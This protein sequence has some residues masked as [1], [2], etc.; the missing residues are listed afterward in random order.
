MTPEEFKVIK[1]LFERYHWA[2]CIWADDDSECYHPKC[3][4]QSLLNLCDEAIKNGHKYPFDK[5]NR[6]L[7]FVQGVLAA[8]GAIDVDTE[9]DV[10][11]HI[12]HSLYGRPVDSFDSSKKADSY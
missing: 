11:R 12:F 10:T 1:Q 3:D 5:M 2:L 9:R 8:R 4:T 7:G 6:W